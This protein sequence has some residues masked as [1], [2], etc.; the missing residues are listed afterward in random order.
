M[1]NIGTQNFCQEGLRKFSYW[2]DG[3]KEVIIGRG[4]DSWQSEFYRMERKC[5]SEYF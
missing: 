5:R 4:V 3:F 2:Q 1:Q